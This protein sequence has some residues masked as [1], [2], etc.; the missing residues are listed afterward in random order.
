[1]HSNSFNVNFIFF[2][3]E[4]IED[5]VGHYE[6]GHG[7]KMN[8]PIHELFEFILNIHLHY[9]CIWRCWVRLRVKV[10]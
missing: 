7:S 4:N 9:A 2:V 6:F 3:P 5:L 8:R 1:M 10:N